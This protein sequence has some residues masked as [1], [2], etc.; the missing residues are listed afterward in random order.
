MTRTL[1]TLLAATLLA[2]PAAAST[3]SAKPFAPASDSR[4][5]ARDITWRC[6]PDAC[7]GATEESRPAV[8]CQG[9]AKRVGRLASFTADGRA[10]SAA[11]L[12]KCNAAAPQ[13]D[14][15]QLAQQR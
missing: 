10:F 4:I 11:E 15:P 14:T 5:I 1:A 3:F 6:G 9:L 8:L 2:G 13:G 12:A 7:Q